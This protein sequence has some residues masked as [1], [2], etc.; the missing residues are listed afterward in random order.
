MTLL[1]G[2]Y[3]EALIPVWSSGLPEDLLGIEIVDPHGRLLAHA[4]AALPRD[5]TP[6]EVVVPLDGLRIAEA[7][8][9]EVRVFVKT[10]QPAFL[11]EA[12]HRGR[13]GMR[14]PVARPLITFVPAAE[15]QPE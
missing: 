7:G 5:D 2:T 11:L 14:A 10:N 12:V 9:H 4:V 1:P 3:R 6:Q 15:E 13:L 8:I